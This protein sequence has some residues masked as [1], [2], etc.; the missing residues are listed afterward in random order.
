MTYELPRSDKRTV[1]VG[2]TG[3][4]KTVLANW[5]LSSR[6]YSERPWYIV[7]FKGDDLIAKVGAKE[8]SIYSPP[9]KKP[10]LYVVRP[11]FGWD[12]DALEAWL[13]AIWQNE[14]CGLYIDEGY[15]IP[16]NSKAF[17]AIITQGRSKNIECIVLVQRPVWV[18]KFLFSEANHFYVMKLQLDSDRKCVSD[19]L[20]GTAIWR[21]PKFHSFWYNADEQEGIF[22]SPVPRRS[23]ILETFATRRERER[24][25]YAL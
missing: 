6:D 18:D 9:P 4:G 23:K 13:Y 14:D 17:R 22:L 5:L 12:D 24:G 3:S 25:V 20:D 16:K 21:L 1:I 11:R 15:M 7:D 8:I 10:G 19:Y 2:S